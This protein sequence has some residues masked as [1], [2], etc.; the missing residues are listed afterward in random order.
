M[1]LSLSALFSGGFKVSFIVPHPFLS[2]FL[3]SRTVLGYTPQS[4]G[5]WGWLVQVELGKVLLN[6]VHGCLGLVVGNSQ[7]KVV[8]HVGSRSCGKSMRPRHPMAKCKRLC[9]PR[10]ATPFFLAGD[11]QDCL[12]F[13]ASHYSSAIEIARASACSKHDGITLTHPGS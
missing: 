6:G 11:L 3:Y 13:V 2:S 1:R 10:A 4:L 12:L 5:N 8:R 7:I 9:S